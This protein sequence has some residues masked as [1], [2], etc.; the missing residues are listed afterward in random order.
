MIMELRKRLIVRMFKSGIVGILVVFMSACG[1]YSM[2][3]SIPPHIKSISIPNVI[4]QT[5]EFGIAEQITDNL[6]EQFIEENILKVRSED[7]SD[8][9][10][11]GTLVSVDEKV[12]TFTQQEVVTEL[13]LTIKLELEWFDVAKDESLL[14][15]T[16]T[17]WG[18]YGTSGDIS[19]DGIDND[20]DNLIDSEDEDE[21]GDPREFATKIAVEKIAEDVISDIVSSW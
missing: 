14:L 13:R 15:K 1:F 5:A 8:S 9:I 19:S 7:E 18:A 2:A 11:R 12:H 6:Q 3:G 10:L 4:N 20:G 16:Y 21:I 17:G